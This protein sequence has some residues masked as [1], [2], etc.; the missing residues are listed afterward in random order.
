MNILIIDDNK[1]ITSAVSQ[2]LKAKGFE[3]SIAN[4]GR[5]GL[6]LIQNQEFDTILLDLSIPHFSGFDIIET[7]EKDGQLKDKKIILF[8]ASAISK[9][10]IYDLLRK[11]G[12]KTWLKKPVKLSEI[13][14][15]ISL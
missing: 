3:V 11:D 1:S 4:D 9:D 14:Q 12:I 2:Y 10:M 8:T 7:L 6:S 5:S 13:V 15:A